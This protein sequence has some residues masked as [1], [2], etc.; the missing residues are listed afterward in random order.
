MELSQASTLH[1]ESRRSALND[2][3]AAHLSSVRGAPPAG[4]RL[5]GSEGQ[6]DHHA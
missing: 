4:A 2:D 3:E 1:R 6:R 5:R